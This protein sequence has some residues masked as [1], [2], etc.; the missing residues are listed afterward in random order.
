MCFLLRKLDEFDAQSSRISEGF[1]SENPTSWQL[2]SSRTTQ[3]K[4]LNFSNGSEK[5]PAAQKKAPKGT[6]ELGAAN[7]DFHGGTLLKFRWCVSGK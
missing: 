3:K 5:S 6:V 2:P 7:V 4:S 1:S